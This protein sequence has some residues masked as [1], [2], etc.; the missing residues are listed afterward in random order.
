MIQVSKS[1]L[2]KSKVE[3]N[4]FEIRS[5]DYKTVF[6]NAIQDAEVHAGIHKGKI[7]VR[8]DERSLYINYLNVPNTKQIDV[9][10]L[11]K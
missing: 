3:T 11:V 2:V 4:T 8:Q 6:S 9:A 10:Y 7:I 1:H 5:T